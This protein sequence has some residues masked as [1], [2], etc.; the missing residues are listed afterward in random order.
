MAEANFTEICKQILELH[1]NTK[2]L[3]D[4]A[5]ELNSEFESRIQKD[6]ELKAD[7]QKEI[8]KLNETILAAKLALNTAQSKEE[9]SSKQAEFINEAAKNVANAQESIKNAGEIIKQALISAGDNIE[10]IKG[11]KAEF[12]QISDEVKQDLASISEPAKNDFNDFVELKR[13]LVKSDFEENLLIQDDKLK[14]INKALKSAKELSLALDNNTFRYKTQFNE[15]CMSWDKVAINTELLKVLMERMAIA[16]I[17]DESI[18]L[19]AKI[20][21][22]YKE[23]SNKGVNNGWKY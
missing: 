6:D 8:I 14:D 1:D 17:K 2:E 21:E 15:L 11:I 16:L 12:S 13:E 18:E 10:F 7:L 4:K 5:K 9:L 22:T 3:N 23:I 20:D 19:K